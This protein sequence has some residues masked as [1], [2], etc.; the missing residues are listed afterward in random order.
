[1]VRGKI[2]GRATNKDKRVDNRDGEDLI[3]VAN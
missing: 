1:M 2:I 3:L